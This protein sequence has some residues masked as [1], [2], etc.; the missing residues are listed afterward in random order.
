M[1]RDWEK[2]KEEYIRSGIAM[3]PLAEKHGVPFRT[4]A[5]RAIRE[6]WKQK[7]EDYALKAAKKAVKKKEKRP[8]E[9]PTVTGVTTVTKMNVTATEIDYEPAPEDVEGMAAIFR[10]ADKGLKKAEA[11]IDSLELVDT[12]TLSQLMNALTKMKEVKD[13]RSALDRQEQKARIANLEK[14]TEIA[15]REPVQIDFSRI[16]EG[17]MA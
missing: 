4:L 2:I 11:Y 10:V 3:R 6:Q 13:L 17:D 16:S 12:Q 5:D 9:K 8:A 7:R 15:A 1:A 14:Q